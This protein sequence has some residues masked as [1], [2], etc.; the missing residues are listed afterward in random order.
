MTRAENISLMATYNQWMNLKI[1]E[2]ARGLSD[3]ALLAD[4]S[5]FFGSIIGTLN[6]LTLGDTVW[7]K[8]FAEHPAQYA[9]LTP[10]SILDTPKRLDQ[11]VFANIREL[12]AQRVW[13][14]Q[15]IL[16]WAQSVSEPDLDQRLR[17]HN[18]RGVA[19]DKNFYS[20]VTHFFNH[21]THHRGQVTTLLTQAGRDVGDTDLLRLID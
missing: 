5:A 10:L 4:R 6:H 17:Y 11:L 12:Q 3:E 19:A 14:D 15:I 18:M 16:D 9:A 1:Y 21:Q 8:R 20:L 2:A 7:L 13:L